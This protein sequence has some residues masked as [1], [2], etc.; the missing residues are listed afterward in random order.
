MR[1]RL[2][3]QTRNQE[4]QPLLYRSLELPPVA[5]QQSSPQ[6]ETETPNPELVQLRARVTE[7]EQTLS[8]RVASARQE[9]SRDAEAAARSQAESALRSMLDQLG[10]SI[11]E[12]AE[13][14]PR[15]RKEIEED[16][17]QLSLAIAR[18]ILRRELN[19]DPC[20]LQGLIQVAFERMGRQEITRV[21]VHPEHVAAL[22]ET[23]ALLTTRQIEI[24]ADGSR[25][26]GTLIFE[27]TRGALDAS[28]DSQLREIELGLADRLKWR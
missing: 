3:P 17:V 19:I 15:L 8:Q 13:W 23:L 16:A 28:I 26:K 2:F 10:R 25:E 21:L 1:S 5:I 4:V 27:T 18:R 9:G 11:H 6:R 12:L 14:K 7:L 24:A 22:R 20:A